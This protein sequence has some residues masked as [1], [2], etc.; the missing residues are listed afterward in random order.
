LISR[1]FEKYKQS[2]CYLQIIADFPKIDLEARKEVYIRLN[3]KDSIQRK[4]KKFE[5]ELENFELLEN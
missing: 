2:V 3:S 4:F 5:L 1:H